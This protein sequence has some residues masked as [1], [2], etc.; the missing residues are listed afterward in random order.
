MAV[1]A[2]L[3][4]LPPGTQALRASLHVAP[5][6]PSELRAPALAPTSLAGVAIAPPP[7]PGSWQLQR[8]LWV[9][10]QARAGLSKAQARAIARWTLRPAV[11]PWNDHLRDRLS[12]H[13]HKNYPPRNARSYALLN[14]A[15]YDAM[16]AAGRA[17]AHFGRAEPAR[18]AFGVLG[19]LVPARGV[20][21]YPSVQA[22]A[23]WAAARV[24]IHLLPEEREATVAMAEEACQARIWA[25]LSYPSDVAA[26]RTIG[27][28][29]AEGVLR[30]R[31]DDGAEAH[32]A[33]PAL[34]G[35]SAPA[36]THGGLWRHPVPT[37]PLAGTWRTWLMKRPEQFR[38]PPPPRP[39]D[40]TFE[41]DHAEVLAV[42]RDIT[43]HQRR[44]ADA[45]ALTAPASDWSRQVI[46]DIERAGLGELA[47]ARVMAYWGRS[48]ADAAIACWDSKYWW[49]Q[50]RPQQEELRRHPSTTWWPYLVTTPS[51]PSF[52]SGH[53]VFS[54][55][56]AAFLDRTFPAYRASHAALLQEMSMSRLWG[57]IHYRT[58][59]T[60]GQA[61]GARVGNLH[62][63]ALAA[64][65]Q[66]TR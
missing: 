26:A 13:R 27:E 48:Q 12:F 41:R 4:A 38:L 22:A 31:Q 39:G 19:P 8:E 23:A 35:L 60:A 66:L 56:S 21:S 33:I 64:A 58:D 43:E 47:A 40:A 28:A 5:A 59:I 36:E 54:G 3:L 15:M 62:A 10:A 50:I 24:L 2:T 9:V 55:A 11:L 61:L 42:T 7:A 51:H 30:W 57:G 34:S 45:F 17:Q 49:M 63:E 18:V 16:L 46:G 1:A 65:E 14:V 37:E 20:A 29:I 53:C 6:E 52:P 25:G 44:A 32:S